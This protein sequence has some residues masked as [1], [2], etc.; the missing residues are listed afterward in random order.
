MRRGRCPATPSRSTAPLS[1]S[2]TAL[3]G[4][5]G[6]FVCLRNSVR[7]RQTT[8]EPAKG[9]TARGGRVPR[10]GA[11]GNQTSGVTPARGGERELNDGNGAKIT[12]AFRC[13]DPS[14]WKTAPGAC[15]D[16][17]D[18]CGKEGKWWRGAVRPRRTSER[19]ILSI[20]RSSED[21]PRKGVLGRRGAVVAWLLALASPAGW[22]ASL[23]LGLGLVLPLSLV[24]VVLLLPPSLPYERD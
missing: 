14:V 8:S 10:A 16:R 19:E 15:H 11:D 5:R 13:A 12:W 20:N 17:L 21:P 6:Q 18:K 22:L 2:E 9:R 3:A 23:V 4:S 1:A 7:R 24:V